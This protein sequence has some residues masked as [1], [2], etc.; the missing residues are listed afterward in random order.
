MEKLSLQS[1]MHAMTTGVKLVYVVSDNERF[2]EGIVTET[3][4]RAAEAGAPY[5][6]TCTDGFTRGGTLVPETVEPL[7][8]LDFA[9]AQPGPAIFL[10]KDLAAF[11][12]A[13]PRLVRK[14]KSFAA[15]T[16]AKAPT[17]VN[18]RRRVNGF[19]PERTSSNAF[20][21][22]FADP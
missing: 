15:D 12:Q 14:L 17:A 9:L 18:Q 5:V 21:K 1:L 11:W 4:A 2:T 13:N 8:A 20:E 6:W 7:A 22:L 19:R 10:M 3:A 16:R